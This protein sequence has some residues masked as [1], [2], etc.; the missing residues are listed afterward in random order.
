MRNVSK[1]QLHVVLPY[2]MALSRFA[3][4]LWSMT[5]YNT[6]GSKRYQGRDRI[7]FSRMV[8]SDE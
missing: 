6:G 8:D 5:K 3:E 1:A 7:R 4:R 2:E